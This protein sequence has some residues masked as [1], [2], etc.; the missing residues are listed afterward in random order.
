[1]DE[2][3]FEVTLL[4]FRVTGR[5]I[6][7]GYKSQDSNSSKKVIFLPEEKSQIA[8]S[9]KNSRDYSSD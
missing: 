8:A 4:C 3:R 1:M 7:L 9:G 5:N 6:L 2:R